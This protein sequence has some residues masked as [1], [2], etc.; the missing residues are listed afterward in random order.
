MSAASICPEFII[1]VRNDWL[2]NVCLMIIR[3]TVI[4]EGLVMTFILVPLKSRL[5]ISRTW[6]K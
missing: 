1:L 3:V 4:S 2:I 6:G 5:G